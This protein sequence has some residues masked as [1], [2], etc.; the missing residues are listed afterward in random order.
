VDG[1]S[2]FC[3]RSLVA[4]LIVLPPGVWRV[5]GYGRKVFLETS[6]IAKGLGTSGLYDPDNIESNK[7]TM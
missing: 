5:R 7:K 2:P 4:L 1:T 3:S 6:A